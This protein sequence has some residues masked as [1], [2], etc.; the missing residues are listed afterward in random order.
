MKRR[1]TLTL[2]SLAA[3]FVLA[4][5]SNDCPNCTDLRNRPSTLS[6]TFS[7]CVSEVPIFAGPNDPGCGDVNVSYTNG[8]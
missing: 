3:A 4:A 1:L 7:L 2:L 5:C 6:Y 8:R